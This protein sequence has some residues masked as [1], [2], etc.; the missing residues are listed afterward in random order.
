[1]MRFF[2]I[3]VSLL[4]SS[5]SHAQSIADL[6]KK[7]EEEKNPLHIYADVYSFQNG[8]AIASKYTEDGEYKYGVVDE[9]GVV[10]IQ[11]NY[12]GSASSKRATTIVIMSTNVRETASWVW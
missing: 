7:A 9:E 4:F 6:A 8:L 11:V 10:Y 1:M 3:I 2:I 5:L 12:D